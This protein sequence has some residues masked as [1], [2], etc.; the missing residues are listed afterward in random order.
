MNDDDTM[1]D[2]KE[3]EIII[4]TL[5]IYGIELGP[6]LHSGNITINAETTPCIV[7]HPCGSRHSVIPRR[8]HDAFVIMVSFF[9]EL[10]FVALDTAHWYQK[11]PMPTHCRLVQELEKIMAEEITIIITNGGI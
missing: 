3:A 8:L 1:N 10:L 2:Q 9:R 6:R 7:N 5:A 4:R 11:G